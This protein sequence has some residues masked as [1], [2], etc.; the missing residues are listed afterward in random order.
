MLVF[1]ILPAFEFGTKVSYGSG[2]TY[3]KRYYNKKANR[4][5]TCDE[6]ISEKLPY[7]LSL[8]L[9]LKKDF[10]VF[11]L[12]FQLYVDIINCLNRKNSIG[13]IYRVNNNIAYQEEMEFYGI[14]PTFGMMFDF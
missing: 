8:D 11:N 1:K 2:Y 6:I 3:P 14:V 4:W 13:H 7:F 12:P 9:R 10:K 5:I